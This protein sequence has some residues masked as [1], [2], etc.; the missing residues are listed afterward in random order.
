MKSPYKSNFRM[1]SPQMANRTVMGVT[2]NHNGIDLVGVD[3]NLYA[4]SDGIVVKSEII[5][6]RNN[7]S[8]EFGNRV[9]YKDT[10]GKIVCY[11]HMTTRN[12]QVGQTVKAGDLIGV[13]GATGRVTGSHLHFEIRDK[14]GIGFK[15]FNA[16][17]YLGITNKVGLYIYNP[18]VKQAEPDYA[19]IVA[20]KCQFEPPTVAYINK[21]KFA[22]L[23][24]KSI[25]EQLK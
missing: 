2:A 17:E 8:W 3:K 6:D 5:T 10:S 23:V 7:Q 24:W 1:T 11:N 9:W 13:E 16:A 4:V 14:L 12:V 20:L 19:A 22:P 25:W 15:C 21:Y 18:P